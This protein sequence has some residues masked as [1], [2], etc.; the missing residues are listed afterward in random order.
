MTPAKPVFSASKEEYRQ[1]DDLFPC[2]QIMARRFCRCSADAQTLAME[3]IS[4]AKMDFA[5][6][7]SEDVTLFLF[8]IMRQ[9]YCG[10]G[11]K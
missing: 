4:R 1:L 8:K 6:R 3:T 7:D 11:C 2:L 9:L 5:R 10:D